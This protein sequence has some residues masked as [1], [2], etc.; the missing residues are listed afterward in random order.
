MRY[1]YGF[2][3]VFFRE[4]LVYKFKSNK[5]AALLGL[6]YKLTNRVVYHFSL[7]KLLQ[8][9]VKL[10]KKVLIFFSFLDFIDYNWGKELNYLSWKQIKNPQ[11]IKNLQS[12]I[13]ILKIFKLIVASKTNLKFD[14]EISEFRPGKLELE[15]DVISTCIPSANIQFN[16]YFVYLNN[17]TVI[18]SKCYKVQIKNCKNKIY[19]MEVVSFL[20]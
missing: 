11:S 16:N 15:L 12:Y 9:N 13:L 3:K 2:L 17:I 19:F 18:Y 10:N 7:L 8:I 5:Y 1:L 14:R 6:Q 4:L 20:T